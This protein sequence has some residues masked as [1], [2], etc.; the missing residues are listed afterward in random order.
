MRRAVALDPG[1]DAA[2]HNYATVLRRLG[3]FDEGEAE[4]E[5]ALAVNPEY[6]QS[7]SD[8]GF[9]AFSRRRYADALRWY[10][11]S[12]GI[13]SMVAAT[14]SERARVRATLGDLQGAAA[15]AATGVRLARGVERPRALAVA[16]EIQ[17]RSGDTAGARQRFQD[18]LR[19]AGWVE[20]V[21]T[22]ISVRGMYEFA[23]AAIAL[24]QRDLALTILERARPRGPWLWSYLIFEEFD[25]IR[26]DARFEAVY[27]EARPAGAPD[28]P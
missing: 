21:P 5:R 19:E 11:R 3:R 4:L 15:D 1:S 22:A 27:R 16:A 18:A 6:L 8:V 28:P 23:L 10:D 13:D 25:P 7:V 17:V 20:G 14:H 26:A 24:G 12:V 9:L 2:L